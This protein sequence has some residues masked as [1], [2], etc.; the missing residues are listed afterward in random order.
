MQP[1]DGT[2]KREQLLKEMHY[3]RE[4]QWSLFSWTSSLLFGTL[5]GTVTITSSDHFQLT[6]WHGAAICFAVATLAFYAFFWLR[7]NYQREMRATEMLDSLIGNSE[8]NGLYADPSRAIGGYT[9]TVLGLATIS[10][11]AVILLIE[12]SSPRSQSEMSITFD[13]LT[14]KTTLSIPAYKREYTVHKLD[15]ALQKFSNAVFEIAKEK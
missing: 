7:E 10:I 4:K 8:L 6:M 11:I 5:A 9:F 1:M 14:K 12:M 2:E 15:S 3:R 13:P